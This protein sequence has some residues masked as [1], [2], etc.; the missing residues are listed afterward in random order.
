MHISHISHG[1]FSMQ[2]LLLF[3]TSIILGYGYKI[4]EFQT[5][6]LTNS[7]CF[8]LLLAMGD[9]SSPDILIG[10]FNKQKR[11]NIISWEL[12]GLILVIF[13]KNVQE[14]LYFPCRK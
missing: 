2:F 8:T 6:Q 1:I 4:G 11:Q 13:S 10:I 12:S 14:S 7:Y 9:Y 5:L 3:K